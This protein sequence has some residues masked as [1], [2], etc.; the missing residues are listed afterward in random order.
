MTG[1]LLHLRPRLRPRVAQV[2]IIHALGGRGPDL[3]II[4]RSAVNPGGCSRAR[5]GARIE[6]RRGPCDTGIVQR[7]A[8]RRT[9]TRRCARRC[10]FYA[11]ATT[12]ASTRKRARCATP[13]STLVVGDIPPLAFEVA[14]RLRRA[15]ASRIAN[16][17][18]DWI[19]ETH[20]GMRAAAPWLLPRHPRVRTAKRRSRSSCRSPAASRSSRRAD[21]CRSSR[22]ARRATRDD[23]RAHFGMPPDRPAVLLSF[24]GYGLPDLD[25]SRASTASS[26]WT[27]V[28]TDRIAGAD[29]ALPQRRR[30]I[31]KTRSSQRIPLRGPRRR[32]RCRRDQARLRH[33]RRVHPAGTAMLYTSRGAVSRVRRA[34]ARDAAVRALPVH[35][36]AICSAGRW[37]DALDALLA[38]PPPPRDDGRPTA[39]S[40]RRARSAVRPRPGQDE[41]ERK[42]LEHERR[43]G[44]P[45][46]RS[47]ISCRNAR[48]GRMP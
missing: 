37:R 34:G 35:L 26:D 1:R 5:S 33:H 10:A 30:L 20:P 22:D 23:T 31:P 12:R 7:P 19:Y 41:R 47:L 32:R 13:T 8:S 42:V 38:Q 3:R 45:P 9:T 21:R 46:I 29:G 27:V 4:I 2:E 6:L 11:H 14:A 18:W 16:F 24:G 25:L 48:P 15:V 44:G 28:T 36:Q 43:C 40:T 17:T 39:P